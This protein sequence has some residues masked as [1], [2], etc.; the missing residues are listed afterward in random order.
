MSDPIILSEDTTAVKVSKIELAGLK[1]KGAD[2]HHYV[3]RFEYLMKKAKITGQQER[4][5]YFT[6]G[7]SEASPYWDKLSMLKEDNNI[8]L[9]KI[10]T[11][12]VNYYSTN[13]CTT[14]TKKHDPDDGEE[15]APSKHQR[16]GKGKGKRNGESQKNQNPDGKKKPIRFLTEVYNDLTKEEKAELKKTGKINGYT[17]SKELNDKGVHTC[18]KTK[19]NKYPN[20]DSARHLK[21]DTAED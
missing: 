9:E 21:G 20:K 7:F 13:V 8:T 11:S 12:L 15:P 18:V 5:R 14:M 3:Q 2:I 17:I 1:C 4:I 16:Q 6:E 10:I 19:S